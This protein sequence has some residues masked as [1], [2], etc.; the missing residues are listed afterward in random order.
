MHL[1]NESLSGTVSVMPLYPD[2]EQLLRGNFAV[3]KRGKK[4]RAVP[5]GWVTD[6]QLADINTWRLSR[7]WEPIVREVVFIGT[8]IYDSRISRDGYTADDI[9]AQIR[10]AFSEDSEFVPTQ[11]RTSIRNPIKIESG[12][13]CLVRV[14]LTLECTTRFPRSELYSVIPRGDLHHTPKKLR[15]AAEAASLGEN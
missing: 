11:K 5:V 4:P 7:K 9:I 8:H 6:K 10:H 12:Y 2:A 3:I 1:S 15:E 14:E 13:G